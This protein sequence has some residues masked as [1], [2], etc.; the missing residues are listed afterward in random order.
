M[1]NYSNYGV[2]YIHVGHVRCGYKFEYREGHSICDVVT[3][4]DEISMHNE[5]VHILYAHP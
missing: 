2:L 4:S 3:F 5:C 1:P